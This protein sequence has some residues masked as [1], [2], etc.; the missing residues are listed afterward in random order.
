[1]PMAKV[2]C[3]ILIYL[4]PAVS[5][6][7][8]FFFF[9]LAWQLPFVNIFK[10]FGVGKWNKCSK[11]GDV[12]E[13]SDKTLKVTVLKVHGLI[14]ASNF[15]QFPKMFSQSMGLVGAYAYFQLRAVPGKFFMVHLDVVVE[16]G[17]SVRVSF[18]NLYKVIR[19]LS[20]KN[21]LLSIF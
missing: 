5:K 21:L 11:E 17:M 10:H 20:P 12:T 18:S 15:I 7:I 3:A 6:F 14:P 19:T 4:L 16:G 2:C 8:F 1:M 9:H 13:V